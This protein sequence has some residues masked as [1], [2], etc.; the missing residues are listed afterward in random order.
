MISRIAGWRVRVEQ[1][2]GLAAIDGRTLADVGLSRATV[3]AALGGNAGL[4]TRHP[5]D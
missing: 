5:F 1:R 4:L 3:N 2:H